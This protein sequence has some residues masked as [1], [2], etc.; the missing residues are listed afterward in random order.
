MKSEFPIV[1]IIKSGNGV[2]IKLLS[3]IR[4]DAEAEEAEPTLEDY[5]L[6]VFG[7]AV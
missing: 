5:Y 3:D 7:G 2:K 6:S 4:P 1:N